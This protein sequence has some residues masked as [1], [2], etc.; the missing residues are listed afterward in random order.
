MQQ[1]YGERRSC[2]RMNIDCELTYR[3]IDSDKIQRGRCKSIGG[4]SVA[5]IST[6]SYELGRALEINLIPGK[7]KLPATLAFIE[8]VRS[9]RLPDGTFMIAASIKSIKAN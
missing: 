5:F 2:T 8:I 4:A 9:S 6:E 1:T 3:L 7:A